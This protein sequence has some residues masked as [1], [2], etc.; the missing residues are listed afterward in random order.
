MADNNNQL[1]QEQ[2]D[3]LQS[4]Q[5]LQD[6]YSRQL[7]EIEE[8]QQKLG[9]LAS[10]DLEL[11]KDL[12]Q[13]RRNIANS[14][15]QEGSKAGANNVIF[16]E[17]VELLRAQNKEAKELVNELEGVA[18]AA[19]QISDNFGE[20]LFD[21][22][23]LKSYSSSIFKIFIEASK[24]GLDFNEVMEKVGKN[25][26]NI[27]VKTVLLEMALKAGFAIINLM[28]EATSE[29]VSALDEA[30]ASLVKL[31][32][33][34]GGRNLAGQLFGD[35]AEI[36]LY[37]L[38]IKETAKAAGDLSQSF[39]GFTQL[40]KE[41]RAELSKVGGLFEQAGG[42][43]K[44]FAESMNLLNKS[45]GLSIEE[46]VNITKSLVDLGKQLGIGQK[47]IQTGFNEA[48]KELSGFG[49]EGVQM[50]KELQVV[51]KKAGVEVSA[52]TKIFGDA[53]DTFEGSAKTAATLNTILGAQFIDSN[54]LLFSS[55]RERIMQVLQAFEKSGKDFNSMSFFM[56]KSIAKRLGFSNIQEA[57]S[58]LGKTSAEYAKSLEKIEEAKKANKPLEDLAKTA[59]TLSQK[60]TALKAQ[61]A[62][63]VKPIV[64]FT[65]FLV[66][67]LLRLSKSLGTFGKA[68]M[69][70]SG[71]LLAGV[72]AWGVYKLALFAAAKG[73][74][75]LGGALAGAGQALGAF[76]A[77]AAKAIPIL[78]AIAAVIASIG[79]AAGGAALLLNS[80]M[81]AI[82]GSPERIKAQAE[83]AKVIKDMQGFKA[84]PLI[85]EFNKFFNIFTD[86]KIKA[87][88]KFAAALKG[89]SENMKQVS[90][91]GG[92]ASAVVSSVT[93]NQK[94]MIVLKT[95]TVKLSSSENAPI[96]K[97]GDIDVTFTGDKVLDSQAFKDAMNLSFNNNIKKVTSAQ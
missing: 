23:T 54:K 87:F 89:V 81:D 68:V 56:K 3:L 2:I 86:P 96:I 66:D 51:A 63:F 71:V 34:T 36:S 10:R 90:S 84:D 75:V 32:G 19:K 39:F 85:K 57:M 4:R 79:V 52:L 48:M 42:S 14:L 5:Q 33:Q 95:N 8:R 61:F 17:A 41:T 37:G 28:K 93:N 88:F 45:M 82:Y 58:I 27:N 94:E 60:F 97:F 72:T 12:M 78:L 69:L 25:M 62:I 80:I 31:T 30:G 35:T 38:T 43:A 22:L 74:T 29:M 92:G 64:E 91:V 55:R 65:T 7:E 6:Y 77:G 46:S 44:D 40:S 47:Q 21:T 76:G 18:G 70:V 73:T 15:E 49:L 50:F 13:L 83:M 20:L 24:K 1:L 16:F 26:E 59:A 67:A 11:Q 9:D 53:M